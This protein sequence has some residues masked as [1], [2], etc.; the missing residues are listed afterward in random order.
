[1]SKVNVGVVGASWFADLWY[2]PVLQMHPD[3]AIAAICSKTGESAQNMAKKY[4]VERVYADYRQM[5]EDENLNGICII[6]PNDSHKEIALAA[7]AKGLHVLCEKPMAMDAIE[8][9]EMNEAAKTKGIVNAIN[10]TY[11]EHPAIQ[12][13]REVVAKGL[14]GDVY[15]SYF[16]YSGDY[17]LNGPPG[18]RGTI[19]K[20]GIGGVLQDLGSH[21]IDMAQFILQ[22]KINKVNG[23]LFFM[24]NGR[25]VDT[26][27]KKSIDQAADSV[28]FSA[29]FAK[30]VQA[31]FHTSWVTPQGNK[32]QTIDIKLHGRDGS[33]HLFTSELGTSLRHAKIG[34][35]WN[36]MELEEVTAFD[37]NNK[38]S[39]Q[40]FRP[41]RLTNKNE[42]WKWIDQINGNNPAHLPTFQDGLNVQR[43]ID[44]VIGK[45]VGIMNQSLS[46]ET[47][48]K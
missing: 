5:L 42:V 22:D 16:E 8:A 43:V 29:R 1:M 47:F 24:E 30:G 23:T 48:Q 10:F 2:L 7:I 28:S 25:L 15:Q 12:K 21:L 27:M 18:W 4:E 38:P 36:E 33:L 39:E 46:S 37:W 9:Y 45:G 14:I 44:E 32:H 26:A 35:K 11:R 31:S 40:A 17:G 41:W 20:G 3:V 19:S 34:G 6:T 13:L